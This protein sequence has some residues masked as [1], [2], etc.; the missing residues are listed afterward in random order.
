MGY[1]DSQ[2]IEKY[3][4][5]NLNR[6]MKDHNGEWFYL[7][8]ENNRVKETFYQDR[9]SIPLPK[10]MLSPPSYEF[11]EVCEKNMKRYARNG[12]ASKL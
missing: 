9:E 10:G 8:I 4:K 6:W 12:L 2:K 11:G 7:T 5:D 3:I 1:E